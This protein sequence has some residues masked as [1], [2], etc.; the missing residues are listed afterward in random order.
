[1][2]RGAHALHRSIPQSQLMWGSVIMQRSWKPELLSLHLFACPASNS[3]S[4]GNPALRTLHC[5]K[6]LLLYLCALNMSH[7][8]DN[9]TVH[10]GKAEGGASPNP[11]TLLAFIVAL[12]YR[13]NIVCHICNLTF[14]SS[15]MNK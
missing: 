2:G 4:P 1:M 6:I 8:I 9:G 14:S 7:N 5:L 11:R 3:V 15:Y 12:P 10:D 13:N